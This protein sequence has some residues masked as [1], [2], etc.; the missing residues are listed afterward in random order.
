MLQ[1]NYLEAE[2]R[3]RESLAIARHD[4]HLFLEAKATNN[5]GLLRVWSR[6]FDEAADWLNRAL[7]LASQL[8]G[9][10][11]V[12]KILT[13]LGWCYYSLGDYE[14]ALGYLN[15][16][17]SLAGA[18]AYAA[19]RVLA[20]QNIGNVH[21]KLRDL[22]LAGDDYRRALAVAR[23]L[24]NKRVTGELLLN[25]GIVALEQDRYDD[26]ELHVR[27]ALKI[28]E[29]NQDLAN[30]QHSLQA[31]GQIWEGRGDYDKAE[32]MYREVLGSPHSTGELLWETRASL[33]SLRIKT[34]RPVEAE[35]EFRTAFAIMEESRGALRS[36]DHKISFFSSLGQFYDNYVD[37]LVDSGRTR[38]AFEVADQSR[39]RQ[40]RELLEVEAKLPMATAAR[41]QETARGLDAVILFYWLA[42][43]R[44][45]LWAVTPGRVQLHELPP[46][47]EIRERVEA[48]Q[49]L[50]Q[51]GRDPLGEGA[52]DAQWLYRTLIGP[53]EA[54]VAKGARVV[55]VPDGPLHQIN[56]E[57]LVVPSP[58]P[59]YW[60]ED[61]TLMV[62]PSVSVLGVAGNGPKK[63]GRQKGSIL[64]IGDPLP[65][66]KEFPRLAHASRELDRIGEQFSP[67]ESTVYS[68]AAADPTVYKASDPGRF[69]FIHFA[70]HAQANRE[71]PLESAVILTARNESSKLYAREI[72][73]VPLR[74]ELVTL[75]AC[76]TAGARTFAGEGLVGLTWAFLSSGAG[77]VVAGL[78]NV[79][80]ASTAELMADLYHGLAQ[81][82]R[83]AEALR[84]AK[85]DLRRSNPAY[86]K[87]YYW[88]PFMIY[89]RGASRR[90]V[91]PS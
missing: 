33:A 11:D 70:A 80:D 44:S 51:Q 42:P 61:V 91:G 6:R 87:P 23:E 71:V 79:E 16:A 78:W 25:L 89:T 67:S 21:Y 34:R 1:G 7:D 17:E 57:T 15:R 27:E 14:R 88:A 2:M 46:E 35:A 63:T 76:R 22:A 12:V 85:L 40:L 30:K 38:R 48:H 4:E 58:G 9:D 86:G 31:E 90:P 64:M 72:I 73:G 19:E 53:A 82:Q 39:A 32:A 28:M 20:L 52:Q 45:F 62:A 13:N 56:P 65:G 10:L 3:F 50:V 47:A 29:E 77:N 60:I 5:L 54:V 66:E 55:F 74:A 8:K 84:Q 18:R 81:G 69:S 68:G 49:S 83:P 41:F 37:F 43:K 36:A 24:G 26:A 59:H 75:S